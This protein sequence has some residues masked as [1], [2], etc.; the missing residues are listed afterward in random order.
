MNTEIQIIPIL[1]HP[2]RHPLLQRHPEQIAPWV[3]SGCLVQ[4]T[5]NSLTGHWGRRA[6]E[7]S[8]WLLKQGLVHIIATDAHDCH[9]RPPVLSTARDFVAQMLGKDSA[10]ALVEVNPGIVV[11]GGT[12]SAH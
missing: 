8:I 5:A 3:E 4:I 6:K 9:N 12:F 10:R 7:V 1:T 2:E 11:E